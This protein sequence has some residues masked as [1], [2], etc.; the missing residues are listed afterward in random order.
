M[1]IRIHF[2]RTGG[3]AGPAMRRTC[4]LDIDNLPADEANEFRKLLEGADVASVPANTSRSVAVRPD[5]FRYRLAIEVDGRQ[6]IVEVSDADMPA[7][8]RP[9]VKWLAKRASARSP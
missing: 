2:E 3:L 4:T 5:A 7:S 8:L 9:L 1:S 6:N